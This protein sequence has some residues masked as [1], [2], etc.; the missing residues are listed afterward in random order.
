VSVAKD[1]LS[2][3]SAGL[4]EGHVCGS[5]SLVNR[6]L[7]VASN[8]MDMIVQERKPTTLADSSEDSMTLYAFL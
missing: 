6:Q 1:L 7:G 3:F 8:L 5:P 4:E 2:R